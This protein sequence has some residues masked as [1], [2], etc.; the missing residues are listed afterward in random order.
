LMR[1]LQ[2]RSRAANADV[3]MTKRMYHSSSPRM[4]G[5]TR[6][7]RK[8]NGVCDKLQPEIFDGWTLRDGGAV[9]VDEG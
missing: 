8:A 4:E 1:S 7:G 6:L 9:A 5:I 2:G 3:L